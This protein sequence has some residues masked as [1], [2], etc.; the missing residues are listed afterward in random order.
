MAETYDIEIC[1]DCVSMISYG[2]SAGLD[3]D[4]WLHRVKAAGM[5]RFDV[6][7]ACDEDCEGFFS[8][9]GCDY[10]GS[11][12]AGERHPAVVLDREQSER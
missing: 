5:D 3:G 11:K 12:L 4:V 9:Y 8:H 1:V 2:E 7:L 10:C 6:D